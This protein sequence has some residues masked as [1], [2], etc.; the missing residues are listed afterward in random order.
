MGRH[1]TDSRSN[2]EV[3]RDIDMT[4][5]FHNFVADMNR[6]EVIA[7]WL[8]GTANA[9][10]RRKRIKELRA[11]GLTLKQIAAEMDISFQRV[12]QLLKKL[13]RS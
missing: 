9:E 3:Q 7:R 13:D 2:R 8:R 12:S 11:K 6:P 1:G 5:K 10:S 4:R